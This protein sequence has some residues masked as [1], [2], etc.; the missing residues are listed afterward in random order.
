MVRFFWLS[1]I[2]LAGC[3]TLA[4]RPGGAISSSSLPASLSAAKLLNPSHDRDWRLDLAVLP[5]ADIRDEQVTVRNIRHC[6]YESDADYVVN[7]YDKQFD[8]QQ[9]RFVDFIVVPFKDSPSLAHTMLSFGFEDGEHLAVS[10]EA[11]LEKDEEYSP[12]LG[13]LRQYELMYV[14]ADERDAILRRTK[15]RGDEVYVYRTIATP[16][17]SRDLF[18]DVM[19]RVNQLAEVPEFYDTLSNNCTTN[20]VS[21]L[22]RLRPGRI[23]YD[24]RVLLPGYS[25]AL[26]YELG[27][28]DTLL[29][30]EETRRRARVTEIANRS[31]DAPNF[32]SRIRL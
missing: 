21:H 27:L 15:H 17:Q 19:Q 4:S 10:A 26:A 31:A 3:Q 9:L 13:E 14:V 16:E 22:N 11:R 5:H 24:V 18:M 28:L 6:A 1:T 23:P 32:S 29:P 12:I 8:L 25:D 20:I 30:F 2:L 7:Y